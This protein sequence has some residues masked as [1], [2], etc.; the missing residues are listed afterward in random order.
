MALRKSQTEGSNLAVG[1]QLR[2]AI[3]DQIVQNLEINVNPQSTKRRRQDAVSELPVAKKLSIATPVPSS[4]AHPVQSSNS[5]Y[6]FPTSWKDLE[7]AI[8]CALPLEYDA[9]YTL[10]DDTWDKDYGRTDRDQNIYTHGR[11]GKFNVVLLV[12]PNMGKVSAAKTTT[13]LR[14]SYQRL[15]LVLVTGICGGVPIPDTGDEILLGD[16][17]VSRHI[18]QYDLGRQYPEEFETKDTTEDRFGRAPPSIR[19]LL[20]ILETNQAREKMESLAASYLQDIQRRA[21]RKVRG[22]DYRYPG[23]SNDL[24]FEPGY[25][26]RQG[27]S[28]SLSIKSLKQKIRGSSSPYGMSCEAA[29]C[30]IQNTIQRER[31]EEKIHLEKQG[32]STE[33][34]AP[35]IFLGT[36]GSGDTV[37]KTAEERDKIASLHDLIAFEMEGA[38]IWDETPCIIIKGVCDYADSHKNKYWQEFA[39]AT[40]ASAT[41]ALLGFYVQ[42]G[43]AK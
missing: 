35:L 19:H 33:A 29:G 23:A 31:V 13:S 27:L 11:L 12:M 24:L 26:H 43:S 30:D 10:F 3:H 18:V 40:A 37:M 20:A 38:G 14:L 8:V 28:K 39:A 6:S 9:V 36:I 34:Q 1:D 22:S 25:Q 15:S 2:K 42:R 16:V 5:N 17:V 7:I 41:K 32:R 21:A 4:Q